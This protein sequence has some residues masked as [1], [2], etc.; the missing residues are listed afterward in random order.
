MPSG[1]TQCRITLWTCSTTPVIAL[2]GLVSSAPHARSLTG[3]WPLAKCN[4]IPTIPAPL[5]PAAISLNG[6]P[7]PGSPPRPPTSTAACSPTSCGCW[8]RTTPTPSSPAPTSPHWLAR[9]GQ[10]PGRRPISRRAQ[11][12]PAGRWAPTTPTP[13]SPAR[14]SPWSARPDSLPR[15]PTST[16][17]CLTT[18]CGCWA[19][20]TPKP[21]PPAATSPVGWVE[22]GQP[23]QSRRPVPRPAQRPA[24]PGLR[25]P[26]HPHHPRQPRP[27]W[28]K[29]GSPPRPPTSTATCSTTGCGCWARTTPTPSITRANLARWLGEAGQPAQAADQFRDLLND[30]LRV[31]GPDH[32]DTL[33]TRSNLAY[34]TRREADGS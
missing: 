6:W 9:A 7:S 12:L 20:T 26:P 34:W 1:S 21:S 24:G 25:P 17:T 30:Q 15:P 29:P 16:A 19:P 4:W 11:R 8:A 13:S 23:G 18:S 33:T 10:R 5:L 3:P 14:T 22:A 32:P 28:A 31:L 2:V 27:R